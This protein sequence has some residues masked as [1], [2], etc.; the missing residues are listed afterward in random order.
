MPDVVNRHTES[1]MGG[2]EHPRRLEEEPDSSNLQEDGKVTWNP[3]IIV[4][5][6]KLLEHGLK[7]LEKTL[8][9]R[10]RAL[11][12]I[13]PKQ[14]GFMPRKSTIDAIF[15]VR[16]VAEKRIE[17]NLLVFCGFVADSAGGRLFQPLPFYIFFQC[18]LPN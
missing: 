4:T 7:I 9:K 1:G 3:V 18:V 15:I 12:E 10:T 5:G 11:V 14:F 2:R 17:G 16:Q 6:I 8:D 13:D